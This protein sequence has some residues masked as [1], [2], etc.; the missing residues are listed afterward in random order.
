MGQEYSSCQL[1][2]LGL[3]S[4]MIDEFGLVEEIDNIVGPSAGDRLLSPGI[5]CKALVL[6]GL[7][8][9]QRTLYMVSSFFEQYDTEF[10]L[11]TG[12]EASQLNDSVL[13]RFLDTIHEYGCTKLYGQLSLGICQKLGLHVSSV[14]MD[15]T[16]FHVDGQYNTDVTNVAD[17]VVKVTMGYSRDHRPDLNQVVLNMIVE[18]EAG[19]VLHMEALDGNASDKKEF[20][21]TIKEYVQQMRYADAPPCVIMDSAG[22][23]EETLTTCG[24]STKWISRV[25]EH[26]KACKE[27]IEGS[28]N[29]WEQLCEGYACIELGSTYGDIAQ[30]WLLIFSQAAYHRE[31]STLAKQ[32]DKSSTKEFKEFQVLTQQIFDCEA[33]AKKAWVN[34]QK[35]CKFINI[36]NL[37]VVSKPKYS[38]KGRPS[39]QEEPASFQYYIQGDAYCD[40]ETFQS[41]AQKKGRFILATNEL[42]TD[43]LSNLQQLMEYKG[44][45][46]VERGFR[47]L[48][49]PQFMAATF[50]VKK[51]ERLEALMF[52]MA[53][54]LTV[55]AAIEYRIRNALK[56]NKETIPNQVKKE[57][58]NPTARWVFAMFSNI[59]VLR[60]APDKKYVLN[61]NEVHRKI[62]RLL[63][64]HYHKYYLII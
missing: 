15:S 24:T 57:I 47:F 55:Y 45:A 8:F 6:N 11:G 60:T 34:F 5:L 3:V 64:G 36:N 23:T 50:F 18:H 31:V 43:K 12:I 22:Y 4:G 53:L 21:R 42:D 26:I 52:I 17:D 30:R 62:I 1:G 20:R 38:K 14:H 29:S 7:G 32:F 25:P 56:E 2:H 58:Q 9:S 63:G 54:S 39:K 51:P 28:Y 13:G 16:S 37:T 40:I 19:I 48:K 10:L 33:D 41:M 44:Q 27:V 61:L 35:K 49:D 59:Q 46:K